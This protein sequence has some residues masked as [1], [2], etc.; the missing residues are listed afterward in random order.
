MEWPCES[1]KVDFEF[2]GAVIYFYWLGLCLLDN[3]LL[4]LCYWSLYVSKKMR[5]NKMMYVNSILIFFSILANMSNIDHKTID[6]E[7]GLNI[8]QDA[9]KKLENVLEASLHL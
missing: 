8:I 1:S 2:F 5:H 9:F 7:E 3:K 6:I 4:S